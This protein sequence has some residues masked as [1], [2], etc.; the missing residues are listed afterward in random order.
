[1]LWAALSAGFDI[2]TLGLLFRAAQH[3]VS[4]AT[5]LAGYAL[6]QVVGGILMLPGGVGAL[7]ATMIGIYATL[8]IPSDVGLTVVLSYRVISFW[9]PTLLGLA[10]APY[11]EHRGGST[12]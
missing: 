10:A 3:P 6:P 5:L 11:L 1:M 2:A 4:A 9:I 7:E 12:S 8:G